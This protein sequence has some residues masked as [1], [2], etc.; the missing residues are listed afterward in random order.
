MPEVG[1]GIRRQVVVGEAAADVDRD[2][3]IRNAVIER[4]S[5]RIT[6]EV[7]RVLFEQVRAHDHAHVGEGQ[8]ELVIL[9]DRHQGRGDVS[10]HHSDVHD[11]A[12]IDVPIEARPVQTSIADPV[13]VR[14]QAHGAVVS[15]H[16]E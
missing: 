16:A 15:K 7:D 14:D 6:V 11:L 12:G 1:S 2:R 13:K 9:V 10:V 4:R 8:K 3:C 5:I